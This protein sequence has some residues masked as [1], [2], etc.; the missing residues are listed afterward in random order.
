MDDE[1]ETK[2]VIVERRGA[3]GGALLAIALLVVVLVVLFFMFDGATWFQGGAPTEI[4]AT[5]DINTP[6]N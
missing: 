1:P 5:V 6:G 3:G 2:I 4:E